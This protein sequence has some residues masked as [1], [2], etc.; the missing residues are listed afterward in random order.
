[1]N[2]VIPKPVNEVLNILYENNY[3]GYI[4]GGTIRNLV[5]EEKP[6]IYYIATNAKVEELN[7][8][9]KSYQ[10]RFCGENNSTFAIDYPKFPMEISQYKSKDNTLEEHLALSDF[11]M[12]ALAYSDEDGLI[13]YYT[14]VL[15]IKNKII[16][17][18]G[19]DDEV[20]TR[21]PIAI[22]RAIR[23]SAEYAMRIDVQT[24]NYMFENR[25][26]LGN[27]PVE[28]LR[29][30][31]SKLLVT[32]RAEFYLKNYLDIF[33]EFIPELALMEGFS[34]NNL[35]HIYD[36]LEH[37]FVTMKAI[38][39]DLDLRL[40]MLFHDLAKPLTYSQDE[41]GVG[42]FKDHAKKSAEMAR[43]ILNRLKFSKKIIQRVIKLIEY[44]DYPIPESEPLVKAFLTKFDPDDIEALFKVKKANYYGKNPAYATELTKIDEEYERVKTIRRKASFI[45][46][47]ELKIN[48]KELVSLGVGQKDIGA[49]LTALHERVLDGEVKNNHEK[50]VSYVIEFILPNLKEEEQTLKKVA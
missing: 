29:D 41:K 47:K 35:H 45:K 49:V 46:K 8:L 43:E 12:N 21:N 26:N 31:L 33:L 37:T 30:E 44:H 10:T 27:V 18:N 16:R 34:Q 4:V 24:R 11:T 50:L 14:G 5:M 3:E 28:R 42:H 40:V 1:M 13:D 38:E 17:L 2:I 9:F 48:G 22:L 23:L 39:P 15:D 25:E 7:R 6:T 20:F 19:Q 36:V 32:P